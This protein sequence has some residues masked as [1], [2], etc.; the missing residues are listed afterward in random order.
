MDRPERTAL[1]RFF[2]GA[3]RCDVP[4]TVRPIAVSAST[5]AGRTF[6]GPDP[7]RPSSGSR[8]AG[9]VIW[10]GSLTGLSGVGRWVVGTDAGADGG[11]GRR[12]PVARV[13][14]VGGRDR[15]PVSSIVPG[16][17]T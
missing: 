2:T 14:V 6:E 12:H 1:T 15:H 4:S 11:D 8:S 10:A 7:N 17:R 5:W 9:M 13:G 16:C 3:W